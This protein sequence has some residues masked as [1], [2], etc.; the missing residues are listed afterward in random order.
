[1]DDVIIKDSSLHHVT[2]H[3]AGDLTDT[4]VAVLKLIKAHLPQSNDY[5]QSSASSFS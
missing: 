3:P 2:A 4:N 5:W 1:M